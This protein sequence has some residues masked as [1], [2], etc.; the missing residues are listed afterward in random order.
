MK[1]IL[2]LLLVMGAAMFLFSCVNK[3]L[4]YEN[5]HAADSENAAEK[6]AGSD[7]SSEEEHAMVPYDTEMTGVHG[8]YYFIPIDGKI[9]RYADLAV[10]DR[11][12]KKTELIYEFTEEEFEEN[13]N[14]KIYKL[15]DYPDNFALGCIVDGKSGDFHEELI[16]FYRPT[17]RVQD[18]MLEKAIENGFVIMENGSATHGKEIWL[19]FYEKTLAGEAA[20][21]KIGK[22]YTLDSKNTSE[23]YYEAVKYDYPSLYLDELVYDGEK[24]YIK[25]LKEDGS[26]YPSEDVLV[27]DNPASSWKY[28]KHFTGKPRSAAALF[29]E[30]DRYVL[31]NADV[32]TWEKIEWG[33]VSSQSGDYIPFDEVYCEYTWK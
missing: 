24:Y 25:P 14:Y 21:V 3:G 9:Y 18:G 6:N 5:V 29:S 20:S 7:G 23:D 22:Y 31:I 1:K 11:K 28:L 26:Y 30:Y 33:M 19:E 13:Y 12:Y 17:R 15:E 27:Y 32:D 16:I 10:M 8:G 2:V 4:L